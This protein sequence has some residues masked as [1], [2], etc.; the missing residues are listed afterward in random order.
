MS[1][2][3]FLD[4]YGT[5]VVHL[6]T[7]VNVSLIPYRSVLIRDPAFWG[8]HSGTNCSGTI[9]SAQFVVWTGGS[10][11]FRNRYGRTWFV[12]IQSVP[13]HLYRYGTAPDVDSVLNTQI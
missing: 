10:V 2:L 11:L 7:S 8:A 6:S 9:W 12:P 1:I 13:E 4:R 3:V 5:G